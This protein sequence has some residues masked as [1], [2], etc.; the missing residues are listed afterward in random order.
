[1]SV[2]TKKL[3]GASPAAAVLLAAFAALVVFAVFAA[4]ILSSC[5]GG[6][7][8]GG[9][10][11]TYS[12]AVT[13]G[14]TGGS[15]AVDKISAAV[16]A[17]V[18]ITVTPDE[19]YTLTNGSLK[20]VYDGT[21]EAPLTPVP[22]SGGT[23]YR[24]TMPAFDVEVTA[25][26]ET[27]PAN[28]YSINIPSFAPYGTI[29]SNEGGYTT[30]GTEVTLTVAPKTGY[31]LKTITVT[32]NATNENVLVSGSGPYKFT[33]PAAGVTVSAEFEAKS[34]TVTI[35]TMANGTVTSNPSGTA[36]YNSTVTLT[37]T[38]DGGYQ[39]K[40]IAVTKT[41][42]T[43]PV[44]LSGSGNT[45]TF[46]MPAGDVTVSAEFEAVAA[47]SGD[48]YLELTN[49]PAGVTGPVNV[50][51]SHD[52]HAHAIDA[53]GAG[54]ISGGS[55]T[56]KLHEYSGDEKNPVGAA[57]WNNAG[58]AYDNYYI[59]VLYGKG[60]LYDAFSSSPETIT[61]VSG[62]VT[63][64]AA[65][66]EFNG[67]TTVSVGSIT[68]TITINDF[69]AAVERI[70]IDAWGSSPWGSWHTTLDHTHISGGN[71][72]SENLTIPIYNPDQEGEGALPAVGEEVYLQL[73]IEFTDGTYWPVYLGPIALTGTGTNL[74]V[75]TI[76]PYTIPSTKVVTGTANI[77]IEG[78][79]IEWTD[80]GINIPSVEV[81]LWSNRFEGSGSWP[82][83]IRVPNDAT[84]G[85]FMAAAKDTE[86]T[87]YE[88]SN[89]GTWTGAS[90]GSNNTITCTLTPAN[91][92]P[93]P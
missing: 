14:L 46:A 93:Y 47:P 5:G 51:L 36:P 11:E 26:F 53:A 91:I 9:G 59:V 90:S 22:G 41:S 2:F 65:G 8:G 64:S 87:R 71:L 82:W 58:D 4:G 17:A 84:G 52:Y 92:V 70:I 86:G 77:T 20:A 23:Q 69:P 54:S 88:N 6:G 19:D 3:S 29:A 27:L 40:T 62:T 7:G 1:M 32:N 68:G 76:A 18:T 25:A 60:Y 30:A 21:K 37:V 89:A 38:P 34:Y 45:R 72:T 75:G 57:S 61:D 39:L 33:M 42:D 10:V 85:T 63:K 66:F 80:I 13:T 81:G 15:L 35:P 67:P 73:E 28:N 55:V 83:T 12:V 78:K 79:T 74:S 50:F 44:S 56:V 24:F 31:Q 43:T 48:L 16:G 49:F